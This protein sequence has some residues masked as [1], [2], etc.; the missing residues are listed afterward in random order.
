MNI[1]LTSTYSQNNNKNNVAFKSD[2]GVL[3]A[4][5]K[6]QKRVTIDGLQELQVQLNYNMKFSD[7]FVK[8]ISSYADDWKQTLVAHAKGEVKQRLIDIFGMR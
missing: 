4:V 7:N 2:Q 5:E 3:N 1:R 6:L 8:K